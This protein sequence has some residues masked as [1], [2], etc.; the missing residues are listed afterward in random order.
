MD[1]RTFLASAVA[2]LIGTRLSAGP[3]STEL[4]IDEPLIPQTYPYRL[5]DL[6]YPYEA[7]EPAIDRQTMQVHHQGHHGGYVSN[8][9]K[10][11]EELPSFQ[12][13]YLD[14]LLRQLN[15][16]P[17]AQRTMVRNHGGGHWNHTFFW[18]ILSPTTQEP[19]ANL[20][21]RISEAFGSWTAFRGQFLDTALKLFGS[22]WTWLIL[23]SDGKLQITTTPNQDNPLMPVAEAQGKPV[24]AIDVWEHAY[25]LKYQN[26][27]V[28][29]LSAIWQHIN[30]QR[31]EALIG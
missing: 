22:G 19:S 8:L 11:L 2:W 17:T 28:E 16:I 7:L 1:R 9:N 15:R 14:D 6:P 12:T 4:L 5:P 10:A 31:V 20:Q 27:R 25:Y 21:R 18:S 29:Y 30:W 26:R 3:G 13:V 24:L 23:T